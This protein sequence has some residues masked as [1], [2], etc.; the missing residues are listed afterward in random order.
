MPR[1]VPILLLAPLK[2]ELIRME[3][4]GVIRA[5]DQPTDWCDPIV[6]VQKPNGKLRVC[7]DLTQLNKG[8]KSEYYELISVDETLAQLG[9]NCKIMVKLDTNSGYWQMPLDEEP[10]LLCTF[11]TPFGR[12]CP[13]R[14]PFGLILCQKFSRKNSTTLYRDYLGS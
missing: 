7:I 2:A 5:V 6:T 9:N 10:Q 8:T 12:Y 3:Q 4:M 11:T 14:G 1:R 13:T